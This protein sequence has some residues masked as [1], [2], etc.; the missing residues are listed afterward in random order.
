MKII[1]RTNF[2]PTVCVIYTMLSMGKIV[3]EFIA[4]GKFGNDQE[5]LLMMFILSFLATFV[6]S[7]HYRFEKL[8][9]LL[10]IAL[11]YVLLI[12]VVMGLTWLSGFFEELHGDAYHDMFWSFTIPYMIGAAAYYIA[13]FCEIRRTDRL[14]QEYKEKV[15]RNED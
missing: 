6:L 11:Q 13:L 9:L 3:L 5:N 8:P 4:Q 12:G 1:N 10:V 14:L 2:I 15:S 7:Q